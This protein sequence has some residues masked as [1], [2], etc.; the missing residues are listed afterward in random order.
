MLLIIVWTAFATAALFGAGYSHY[1]YRVLHNR[2]YADLFSGAPAQRAAAASRGPARFVALPLI[3]LALTCILV[4][5][6]FLI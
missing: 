1:R 6:S 4:P 2:Y 3:I 5:L